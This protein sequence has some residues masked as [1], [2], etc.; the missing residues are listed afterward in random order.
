MTYINPNWNEARRRIEA[1]GEAF[2][3]SQALAAL[4]AEPPRLHYLF[5]APIEIEEHQGRSGQCHRIIEEIALEYGVPVDL[6]LS[7]RRTHAVVPARH[8]AVY[9]CVSETSLTLHVLARMFNRDHSTISYAVMS[10]HRRTGDPMPRGIAWRD[11]RRR[12]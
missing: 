12:Y 11:R 9:R 2:Q 7:D 6:I 8:A 1:A 10:H 3:A 5:A 4:P